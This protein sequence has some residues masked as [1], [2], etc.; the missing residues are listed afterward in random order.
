MV[1]C[2]WALSCSLVLVIMSVKKL[3]FDEKRVL[4][5]WHTYPTQEGKNCPECCTSMS[6]FHIPVGSYWY[7]VLSYINNLFLVL[8]PSLIDFCLVLWLW[9]R[10]NKLDI[11]RSII[12]LVFLTIARYQQTFLTWFKHV[13]KLWY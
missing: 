3:F 4:V 1:P 12:A 13:H 10:Y 5:T 2:S 8:G 6:L 7:W 11:L 9:W